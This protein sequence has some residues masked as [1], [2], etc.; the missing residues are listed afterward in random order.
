MQSNRIGNRENG[1]GDNQRAQAS[2][3]EQSQAALDFRVLDVQFVLT[4]PKRE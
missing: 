3:T 1:T 2:N 4:T